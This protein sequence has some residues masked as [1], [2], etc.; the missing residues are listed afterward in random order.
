MVVSL[1]NIVGFSALAHWM[2]QRMPSTW[3]NLGLAR[4]AKK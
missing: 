2:A 1:P 4:T 3:S